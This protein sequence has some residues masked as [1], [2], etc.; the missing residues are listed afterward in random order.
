MDPTDVWWCLIRDIGVV[1][2][3]NP[4]GNSISVVCGGG[5]APLQ[6]CG[7]LCAF[8]DNKASAMVR[9]PSWSKATD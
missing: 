1:I 5:G 3:R 8:A 6:R 2:D 4:I 7:I 9:W